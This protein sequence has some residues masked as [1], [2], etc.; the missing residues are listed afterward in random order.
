M[1]VLPP[2]KA[3]VP[4]YSWLDLGKGVRTNVHSTEQS[5]QPVG[6][7]GTGT[8]DPQIMTATSYQLSQSQPSSYV[9]EMSESCGPVCARVCGWEEGWVGTFA[10]G[11]VEQVLVKTRSLLDNA[12]QDFAAS[13][14]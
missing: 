7:A 4:V 1:L 10:S 2:S 6:S 13:Q 3:M 8:R 14:L 12:W 5:P 11:G 9:H